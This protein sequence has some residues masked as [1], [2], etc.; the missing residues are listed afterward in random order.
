MTEQHRFRP[1][2]A[3]LAVR[4]SMQFEADG[5]PIIGAALKGQGPSV[6]VAGEHCAEPSGTGACAAVPIVDPCTGRTLGIVELTSELNAAGAFM[7]P[8][9]R[10]VA[11]E[12]EHRLLTGTVVGETVLRQQFLQAK[13]SAKGALVSLSQDSMMTNRAAAAILH[14]S[15]HA[16]LWEWVTREL[17]GDHQ[18][19]ELPLANGTSVEVRME[20][21]KDG[22][23]VVGALVRLNPSPR[24]DVIGAPARPRRDRDAP[25]FGWASLTDTEEDVA[26]LVADGLTNIQA[27]T[28]L[29][30]SHHTVEYHLRSIYRKLGIRSRVHLARLVTERALAPN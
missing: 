10:W 8:F 27:G 3:R 22:A 24:A 18:V 4:V 13:R 20:P 17:R 28:R 23:E 6:A 30:L 29:F 26:E 7:L 19:P 25:R 14:P 12:V 15:D 16:P 1:G 21:V 2:G 9:V 5:Q 11:R